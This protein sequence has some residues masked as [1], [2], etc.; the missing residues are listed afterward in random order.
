VLGLATSG[1]AAAPGG[2]A[3]RQGSDL[4]AAEAQSS[5]R[6]RQADLAA[7]LDVLQADSEEVAASLAAISANVAEQQELTRQ[8]AARTEAAWQAEAEATERADRKQAEVDELAGQLRDLGLQLYIRPPLDDTVH[9][10]VKAAPNDAPTALALARIRTED[11]ARILRDRK[12]AL[13]ELDDARQ[14]AA[15]ARSQAERAERAARAELDELEAARLQQERFADEVAERIEL[16]MAESGVLSTRDAELSAEIRTRE[17]ELAA[18]LRETMASTGP[19]TGGG[20]APDGG[21]PSSPTTTGP[22][23]P[24][25]A[26][27]TPGPGGGN[28]GT[29]TPTTRPS[30]GGPPTT[31]PPTVVI[32]PVDTVWVGGIEVAASIAGQVEAMLAAAAADGLV[33]TGYGYRNILDQIQIRREVCGPTDWDIFFRPSWECTP[34]AAIPGRSMHEKGLAIDF[35]EPGGDLIRTRNH[36]VIRWLTANAARFGFYNL[37]SEPWH[38][39]TTGG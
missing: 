31:T 38:W 29:T 1:A 6:R 23:A 15:T 11:V 36:P 5:L 3:E 30:G 13:A 25:P 20:S 14:E 10:V 21:A 35:S 8:A 2:F 33:L 17:L 24:P 12:T 4:D 7:E 16:A 26:T 34:P 22:P 37:P 9:A 32:T 18:L 27:T 28:P 19:R 39:S